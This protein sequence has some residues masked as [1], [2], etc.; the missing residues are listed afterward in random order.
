MIVK[1]SIALASVAAHALWIADD[2]PRAAERFLDAV[3]RT[4]RTLERNPMSG[5]AFDTVV[6]ELQGLRKLRVSGFPRHLIFYQPIRGG[7]RF[8]KLLHTSRNIPDAL[9]A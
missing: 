2:N 6:P 4:L 8:V 1:R 5:I 7:I 9:E 3:E